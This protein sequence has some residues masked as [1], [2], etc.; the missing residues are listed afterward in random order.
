MERMK[1]RAHVTNDPLASAAYKLF[2]KALR[3]AYWEPPSDI[4]RYAFDMAFCDDEY[5]FK[6]FLELCESGLSM[7]ECLK[8]AMTDGS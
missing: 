5:D 3:L 1:Y 7:P 6:R 8:G 4:Q 2:C